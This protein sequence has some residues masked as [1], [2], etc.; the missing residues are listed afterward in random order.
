M[1][2]P[3]AT[4]RLGRINTLKVLRLVSIGAYLEW[5]DEAGI[6]LP[7]RYLP[8]GVQID[9]ELSVFVYLDNESRP[10][11]TTMKP[12]IEV[13]HVACLECVAVSAAGAF[14][15]WGIHR[16]LFVPFAEGAIRM[17]EGYTYP[18]VAYLDHI[19]GKIVGSTKLSKHIGTTMP[20]YKPGDKVDVLVVERNDVGYRA[21]IEHQHWGILY[22]DE[23][24]EPPRRGE[25]LS[26][27]VVRLREDGKVDL[28][29]QPV[30]YQRISGEAT[31]LL[32][33][34]RQRGGNLPIGDKSDAEEIMRITGM[35]KKAFKM[36]VG[37]LYKARKIKQPHPTSI[38]LTDI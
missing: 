31:K 20:T 6:L 28:S 33:L 8:E 11:A 10:I 24:P 13:G 1:Q 21:V 19:S 5:S 9:D 37:S 29:L 35:S 38:E 22:E 26:A 30:G 16:D 14:V 15:E 3:N 7:K 2:S 17:R 25:V 18:I 27:Y 36:T 23:C 4:Y 32:R 12:L 34:L